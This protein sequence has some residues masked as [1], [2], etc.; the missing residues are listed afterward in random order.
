[1][2]G[3]YDD[4]V[5]QFCS[6][7]PDQFEK[8]SI[9]TGYLL[10]GKD[11]LAKK[12]KPNTTE[13][14]S[15]HAIK[16]EKDAHIRDDLIGAI[17]RLQKGQDNELNPYWAKS[18]E[19]LNRI[20]HAVEQLSD[21][22]TLRDALNNNTSPLYLALNMPRIAPVTFFGRRRSLYSYSSN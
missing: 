21:S 14:A 5:E 13:Y 11:E 12:Y 2:F 6:V 4:K 18:G 3:G 16:G 15:A 20:F 7:Y 19:K 1:M 17:E 9:A 22:D 10:M 8:S